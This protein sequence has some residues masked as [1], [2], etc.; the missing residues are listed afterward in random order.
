MT[1]LLNLFAENL[2]P[3]LAAATIGF[4]LQ[5]AL[6]LDPRPISQ[7]IFFVFTPALVLNLLLNTEIQPS[8]IARMVIFAC[9]IMLVTGL[10]SWGI[11]K[12]LKLSGKTVSALVLVSAFSNN[13]NFGLSLTNFAFGKDALAWAV[14]YF[15]TSA[16][17]INSIGVYIASSGS[18]RP[19]EAIRG[20]FKVPALYV[21]PIAFLIRSQHINLPL[22]FSRPIELL[23]SAAIP[24][25]LIVLGMQIA[26]TGFPKRLNL[27]AVPTG[28]RLLAGPLLAIATISF[29]GLEGA[30][31]QAGVLEAGTPVAVYTSIL[32]IEYDVDP[33]FVAGTILLSTLLSPLTITP[34][35]AFLRG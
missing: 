26:H 7:T 27:I 34:L 29:F 19:R 6:R 24:S 14:I 1:D 5:R 17:V 2:F 25:M 4:T 18:S 31:R 9:F 13:G 22:M 11:S 21:L 10:V 20:L 32:S 33:E 35:I 3:V 28:I 16:I 12:S 8:G 30:S 23:G 15:I